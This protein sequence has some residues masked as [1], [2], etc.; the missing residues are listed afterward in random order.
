MLLLRTAHTAWEL[1]PAVWGVAAAGSTTGG[2]ART[3]GA[4][5]LVSPGAGAGQQEPT[6][7]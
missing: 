7:G 4:V 5:L 3:L 1:P 2:V 6:N